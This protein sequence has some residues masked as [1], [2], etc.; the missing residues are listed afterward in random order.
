MLE[1]YRWIIRS[2][3]ETFELLTIQ[4]TTNYVELNSHCAIAFIL[5]LVNIVLLRIQCFRTHNRMKAT[6]SFKEEVVRKLN[7]YY[8]RYGVYL[9][10]DVLN[11]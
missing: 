9:T 6:L 2:A 5:G 8:E 1:Y 11:P 7:E 3:R 4:N 10:I